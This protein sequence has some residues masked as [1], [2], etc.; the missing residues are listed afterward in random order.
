MLL[1]DITDR[2]LEAEEYTEVLDLSDEI[3]DRLFKPPPTPKPPPPQESEEGEPD[4]D[5]SEEGEEKENGS[6]SGDSSDS[7]GESNSTEESH[8]GE[9][10]AGGGGDES[11][12]EESESLEEEEGDEGDGEASEDSE[13]SGEDSES[14]EDA[15]DKQESD[16]SDSL[17]DA[18]AEEEAYKAEQE[19]VEQIKKAQQGMEIG[20]SSR[21]E[22]SQEKGSSKMERYVK[23]HEVYLVASGVKEDFVKYLGDKDK[24]QQLLSQGLKDMGSLGVRLRYL[25]TS[26]SSTNTVTGLRKGKRI[27]SSDL[28]RLKTDKASGKL[29]RV[30]KK[31]LQARNTEIAISISIDNSGSMEGPK[32]HMAE[33]LTMALGMTLQRMSIP[34]E[35]VGHTLLGS[36]LIGNI[37]RQPVTLN[38]VKSYEERKFDIRRAKF[39]P[40]SYCGY[41]PDPDCLRVVVPRLLARR[42]AKKLLLVFSDGEPYLGSS[43]APNATQ[44]TKDMITDARDRGIRVFCFGM[45]NVGRYLRPIYGEDFVEIIPQKMNEMPKEVLKELTRILRD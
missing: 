6:S 19:H 44:I 8:S 39:P 34:F 25:F 22:T 16:D 17:E 29:P 15:E 20:D 35:M 1:G 30:W 38:I 18:E 33:K 5:E 24:C 45:G 36:R 13:S 42:E 40:S 11:K 23:S 41:T 12:P 9:D 31:E 26:S 37:R 21:C 4:N 14:S 28:H 7:S 3:F 32:S 10:S 43:R 27:S 2:V